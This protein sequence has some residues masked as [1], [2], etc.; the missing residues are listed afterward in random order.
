MHKNRRIG[1]EVANDPGPPVGNRNESGTHEFGSGAQPLP[2]IY[3]SGGVGSGV[4]SGH[5]LNPGLGIGSGTSPIYSQGNR[6]I[7]SGAEQQPTIHPS[8]GFGSGAV[9]GHSLNPGRGIGS[10]TS[11]IYSQES[12]MGHAVPAVDPYSNTVTSMG[13]DASSANPHLRGVSDITGVAGYRP[14][15]NQ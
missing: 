13:V 12:A 7:G 14:Y 6:E 15:N 9:S 5:G 10:G 2:T 4:V 3:P 1:S 8:G 11:P